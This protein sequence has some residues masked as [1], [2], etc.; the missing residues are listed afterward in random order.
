MRRKYFGLAIAA[1]ATTWPLQAWGGDREIAEQIIK[2]LKTNRESGALKDFTLDMKVDKGVV[3]FRGNVSEDVQKDL[4]LKTADGIDGIAKVV[5]EVSVTQTKPVSA[6]TKV[7]KPKAALAVAKAEPTLAKKEAE[8]V[9]AEKQQEDF[10]FSQALAQQ[11]KVIQS[12]PQQAVMPGKIQRTAAVEPMNDSQVV[13]AVVSA[14]KQAQAAGKLRGFGVDVK[15]S[16][17]VLQLTG[18]ARSSTQ[19][20]E[21]VRIA[22]N[23]PGVSG[24][25]ES[26]AIPT[27]APQMGSVANSNIPQLPQPP[28]LAEVRPSLA[29][30]AQA[31]MQP[32]P[33]MSARNQ[34]PAMSAGYRLPSN[35]QVQATPV[36]AP[37]MG[38]PV[39][40]APHSPVGA[41]RYD[42][43]NLP[44]YAWPGYS[45]YPNYAALTYPQ[46]YSPSAWPYIGP[47][48]PYPQVPLGWRKVS[49]EWDD[50]WWM[51][52][53]TD[54]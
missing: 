37:I 20:D 50:G 30:V 34:V 3:L 54:R 29:P 5:D 8:P 18:R 27:A 17:G 44:N 42:S 43:P 2:R 19:R 24:V 31:P 9:P 7:V 23:V 32:A 13:S 45:A 51:L 33:Q 39:P 15:S 38:Q 21:I 52:D 35:G 47:F 48:Y 28:S 53:F 41:P 4:V 10:S 40:M 6:D 16:N 12:R 49:L 46:Q 1:I 25:R 22:Q 14:L 11:A 36:G 26:I